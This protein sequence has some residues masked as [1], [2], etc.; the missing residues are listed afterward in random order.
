M[1]LGILI[2]ALEHYRDYEDH[3]DYELEALTEALD[4]AYAQ[5]SLMHDTD[6]SNKVHLITLEGTQQVFDEFAYD[7]FGIAARECL[8]KHQKPAFHKFTRRIKYSRNDAICFFNSN[9]AYTGFKYLED[10]WWEMERMGC[11]LPD[12]TYDKEAT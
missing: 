10:K 7:D 3:E 5:R 9:A 11:N 6:W 4:E 8:N 12:G 2:K 1:Y